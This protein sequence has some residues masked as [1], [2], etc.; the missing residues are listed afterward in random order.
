M[1]TQDQRFEAAQIL[2]GLQ[3][4]PSELGYRAQALFAETLARMG[5]IIEAVLRAG[6]PDVIARMGDRF[7]R[8]QV[9]ATRNRS[10]SLATEDLEGIRP[11]FPHEDGYLA[12]LDLAAPLAWTC[13]HYKYL[14]ALVG[15]SVP[16]AMLKSME[17]GSF[18][19]QCSDNCVQLVI[20]HR[21]SIEA[22]TFSLLR[23]RVL[24]EGKTER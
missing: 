24:W 17:D 16:I 5:A 7:L 4:T 14:P 10:F 1:N 9:K 6:H 20:E 21:D 22:F 8:I 23:K 2:N 11:R 13:I 19:S 15:R 3:V 18:S 12:L